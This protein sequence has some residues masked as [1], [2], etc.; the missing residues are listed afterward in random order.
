M[1]T[2]AYLGC[3]ENALNLNFSDLGKAHIGLNITQAYFKIFLLNNLTFI[4]YNSLH[5]VV[6]V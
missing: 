4:V 2:E 1:L 5:T 3:N 6:T